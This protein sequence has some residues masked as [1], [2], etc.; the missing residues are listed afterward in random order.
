M[1]ISNLFP[2]LENLCIQQISN[3]NMN[4]PQIV[5]LILKCI[6]I[7]SRID[8]TDYFQDPEKMKIW[9]NIFVTI[10]EMPFLDANSALLVAGKPIDI[11]REMEHKESSYEWKVKIKV[12]QIM[13]VFCSYS[14]RTF[15]LTKKIGN[16]NSPGFLLASEFITK[17]SLKFVEQFY[18]ILDKHIKNPGSFLPY[19]LITNILSSF[20]NMMK[21]D[22]FLANMHPYLDNLL[23]DIVLEFV[24]ILPKDL[25]LFYN[26]PKE[27]IYCIDCYHDAHIRL[28]SVTK[29]LITRICGINHPNGNLFVF[30][31]INHA[32]HCFEK[33]INP[34]NNQQVDANYKEALFNVF[35]AI[36]NDVV[37]QEAI[38]NEIENVIAK[39]VI[40]ELFG[41]KDPIVRYRALN[42]LETYGNIEFEDF[43]NLNQACIGICS[44]MSFNTQE[45]VH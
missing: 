19:G 36:K 20:D 29:E 23:F 1:V 4:S 16:E 43:N 9:M 22:F 28:K 15:S 13:F 17:Y 38:L 25:E 7:S 6:V 33:G 12:S 5:N 31:F 42:V 14:E 34:R 35:I 32:S 40:P 26:D 11:I 45:Q 8:P 41:E 27:F 44:S 3:W 30:Q 18:Q 37:K 2:F 21:T 10:F 24:K 39:S